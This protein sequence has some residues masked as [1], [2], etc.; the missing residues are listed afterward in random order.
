[1]TSFHLSLQGWEV[2]R[3]GEV[4]SLMSS[5][6]MLAIDCEM[7]LCNDGTEGVVRVCVVDDKLKVLDYLLAISILRFMVLSGIFLWQNGIIWCIMIQILCRN[8][9][10]YQLSHCCGVRW[11]Q[12]V[13]QNLHNTYSLGIFLILNRFRAFHLCSKVSLNSLSSPGK[14]GHICKPL[15]SCCWL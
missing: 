9:E 5:S 11:I 2:L 15:E 1:M 4:S 12:Y 13:C 10:S 14:V 3:I 8:I 6:A 7:V